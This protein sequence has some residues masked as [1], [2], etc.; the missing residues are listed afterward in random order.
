M[1]NFMRVTLV[2]GE[3]RR[4]QISDSDIGREVED[5]KAHRGLFSHHWLDTTDAT[6]I[7]RDHIIEAVV[8][9]D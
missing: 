7:A 4:I 3:T 1:P 8:L 9:M 5:F 6:M 2:N